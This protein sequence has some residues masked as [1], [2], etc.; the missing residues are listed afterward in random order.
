MPLSA[1]RCLLRK[2]S[3]YSRCRTNLD[4]EIQMFTGIHFKPEK[5]SDALTLGRDMKE[6]SLAY[7]GYKPG[8]VGRS[9]Q[10]SRPSTTGDKPAGGG[11]GLGLEP[12]RAAGL[13]EIAHAQDISVPLS[14]RDHAARVEQ[15]E[16]WPNVQRTLDPLPQIL[17]TRLTSG[18]GTRHTAN[19]RKEGGEPLAH[20]P[21]AIPPKCRRE[22]RGH[23]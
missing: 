16:D 21:E 8:G 13:G 5:H 14:H 23:S 15:I 2:V 20:R 3:P 7:L 11:A 6:L 17:P 22:T 4:R 18:V 1:S 10:V 19:R 9:I 12:R